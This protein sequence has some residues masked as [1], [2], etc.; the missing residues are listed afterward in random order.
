MVGPDE[1]PAERR[2]RTLFD[3]GQ[4][5]MKERFYRQAETS[6]SEYLRDPRTSKSAKQRARAHCSVALTVL[7]RTTPLSRSTAEIKQVVAHLRNASRLPLALVLA[8]LVR[9][10]FYEKD[11]WNVPEDLQALCRPDAVDL[12]ERGEV[13]QLLEHLPGMFGPTWELIRRR[14]GNLGVDGAP[15]LP[16]EDRRA[17]EWRRKGVR[18]YFAIIPPEPTKPRYA[19]AWSLIGSGST[20]AVLPCA[21][22]YVTTK[23]YVG[24]ALLV[25][26]YCTS[27]ALLFAGV[28]VARDCQDR[29]RRIRERE[30]AIAASVPQPTE[31]E[32]DRW[33]KHD[34]DDAIRRGAERHRIDIELGTANAG[35][36]IEP[37]AIVGISKLTGPYSVQRYVRDAES[38]SGYRATIEKRPL[39]RS[40]VGL[41]SRLR[42]SHYHILV[43][44]L[45]ERRIGVFE[46]DIDLASRRGIAEATHSFSYDDVVTMSSRRLSSA[47]G[48]QAVNILVDPAGRSETIH[49]DNRF[50]L[51]LVNGHNI[52]VS[53]AVTQTIGS[54]KASSI[55]WHNDGVQ[56][57]I[58]R[59]VWALK[60]NRAA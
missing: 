42:S 55:A 37:Q 28:L 57:S 39:A 25:L 5:S 10:T 19:L 34:V 46:C 40:R 50:F 29:R 16:V 2:V 4:R 7:A 11:G 44:F 54:D 14:A 59:M 32:L 24:I 15:P 1:N 47:D 38:P 8:A 31:A 53:T 9:E 56:R 22:L 30:V 36:V 26:M 17:D 23:W 13:K 6:F 3:S 20:F 45:T 51:S 43:L 48:Q 27:A 49:G 60:D 12:L 35:L 18:R 52:E 33:L 21:G 58:E 41:D